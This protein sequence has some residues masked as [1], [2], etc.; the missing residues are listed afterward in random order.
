MRI[1]TRIFGVEVRERLV[2]EEDLGLAH[3][4]AAQRDALA[5]AARERLG[6]APEEASRPSMAAASRTLRVDLR[7]GNFRSFS[8]KAM[9]S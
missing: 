2:E 6:L 7:L 9:F 8:P 4:G 1:E 5:L 3:D